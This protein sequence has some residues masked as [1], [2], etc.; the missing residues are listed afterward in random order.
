[1]VAATV[2]I[3]FPHMFFFFAL[4]ADITIADDEYTQFSGFREFLTK[5]VTVDRKM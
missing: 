1:M 2:E 5:Q 3:V 4:F